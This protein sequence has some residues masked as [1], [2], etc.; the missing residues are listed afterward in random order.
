MGLIEKNRDI[1]KIK[2]KT[3]E[4]EEALKFGFKGANGELMFEDPH[5]DNAQDVDPEEFFSDEDPDD[6][7]VKG[8]KLTVASFSNT[9]VKSSSE[10]LSSEWQRFFKD[11]E[12]R[13]PQEEKFYALHKKVAYYKKGKFKED[14]EREQQTRHA[15]L[16]EAKQTNEENY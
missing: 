11:L 9:G 6:K 1:T 5:S 15:H 10:K 8:V 12:R 13:A 4:P 3:L 2:A 7:A 14:Y 16:E